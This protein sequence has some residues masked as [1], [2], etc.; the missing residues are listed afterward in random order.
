MAGSLALAEMGSFMAGGRKV[1]VEGQPVETISLS[2]GFKDYAYDPN[3]EFWIDQSY[4]QFFVP[5]HRRFPLPVVLVHGGG[6]TGSCWETTPDGRMGWLESLLRRG[7]ACHVIDNVER[8]RAGFSCLSGTWQGSPLQ[9][10]AEE[11]WTLFRIG[12]QDGFA[13]RT[14]F[15][16]TQFPVGAFDELTRRA[17]PRWLTNTE[18]QISALVDAIRKIGPCCLIGHS[19]GGGHAL[20]AAEQV[21]DLVCA[22]VTLEPHGA[23]AAFANAAA[24]PLLLVRGDFLDCDDT[25]RGLND[26]AVQTLERWRAVGGKADVLDLPAQGMRG[27]SHMLMMDINS[28]A[29]LDLVID[30]LNRIDASRTKHEGRT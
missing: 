23:P 13:S 19:Q 5:Q 10:S 26:N 9:R 2:S 27:N 16:G 24:H 29:I 15:E 14:A 11:A 6:L 7:V 8:G 3:G 1:R 21:P 18:A 20:A 4:V 28:E 17:V 12:T 30:W 25:W 22:C